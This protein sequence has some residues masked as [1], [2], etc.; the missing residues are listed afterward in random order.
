[1]RL[2]A[3][4]SVRIQSERKRRVAGDVKQ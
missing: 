3:E 1:M 4:T 2:F